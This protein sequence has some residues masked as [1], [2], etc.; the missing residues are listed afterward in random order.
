MKIMTESVLKNKDYRLL[1]FGQL[2]SNL[3]TQI[4]NFAIA[5]Y[6][7]N[8][9]DGNA[10]LAGIY[11]ATGGLVFFILTPFAGAIVD[12]LDKV[13]IVYL[14]DFVSGITVLTGGFFIMSGIS[15]QI[16]IIL[17]FVMTVILAISGSLFNPA[18]SSLP[19]HILQENQLQQ[20]SSLSQ[21]MMSLYGILG[22]FLGGLI[23]AFFSIE[24]IFIFNGLTFIASGISEMFIKVK[25]STDSDYKITFRGTLKDV[26]EGIIY[27]YNL[28]PIFWLVALASILNFA[29]IPLIA[30]G[31][32]Y[33]FEVQLQREAYFL[34]I[35]T[36]T[37][38]LG[39][40]VTSVV[41]GI[42]AQKEKVSPMIFKG[43]WGMSLAMVVCIAVTHFMVN[44][45][46]T[47]LVFMIVSGIFFFIAGIFN[48]YI[49]IPFNVAI[50]KTVDKDKLGRVSS[51]L[52]IISM[53]FS[54]I[55][56]ALGGFII[57]SLGVL[58]LF[59]AAGIAMV[60]ISML[61]QRNKYVKQ[62]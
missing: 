39:V 61:A 37:F 40:T 12:R 29:T 8:V 62:L 1:F 7:L 18:I 3:G 28:K 33:L 31:L 55:A 21:G 20:A 14:M 16:I 32:P 23:Y 56:I 10:T 51:T 53:G 47:F 35:L 43:L 30:N 58:I 46:V 4:Y 44:G 19:P 5:L 36:S 57:D 26:K 9:T 42:S 2:V 13:K 24:F 52:S 17:L 15:N 38:P 60:F 54:P 27:V 48:G 41:L 34:A 59:Y 25:T 11:M 6:I 50:M 22:A 49:N 45:N